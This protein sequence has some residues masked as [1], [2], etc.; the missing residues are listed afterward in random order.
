MIEMQMLGNNEVA[1]AVKGL[2]RQIPFARMLI[3]NRLANA[4]Q[5]ETRKGIEARF[6]LRRRDFVLKTIYRKP[7]EDFATKTE[8]ESAVRVRDTPQ[9]KGVPD[10]LA[11]FEEGGD[12]RPREGSSI[13]IPV[14]ARRNKSDIVTTAN[15]PRAI[16]NRPNFRKTAQTIAQRVGRG[17]KKTSRVW[18]VLKRRVRIPAKLGMALAAK[19]A[20][21]RDFARIAAQA[22]DEAMR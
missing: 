16:L 22:V 1:E 20:T 5:A 8:G 11:K 18:F 15:R 12:K 7:G 13:A 9:G 19:R 2:G 4:A 17:A 10:F 14:H 3:L 21:E 6:T